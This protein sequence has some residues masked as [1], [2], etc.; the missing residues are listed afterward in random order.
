[1]H[2]QS[3]TEIHKL[4]P[5]HGPNVGCNAKHLLQG[6]H[7]KIWIFHQIKFG[8]MLFYALLQ[9][10]HCNYPGQSLDF[11]GS[12]KREYL[13]SL[14]SGHHRP[15]FARSWLCAY[16]HMQSFPQKSHNIMTAM[17]VKVFRFSHALAHYLSAFIKI[18]HKSSF[19]GHK[20]SFCSSLVDLSFGEYLVSFSSR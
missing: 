1:M 11:K 10:C 19:D 16:N 2:Y 17:S 8:P 14:H 12:E 20:S 5:S 3:N 15:G 18:G 13:S 4:W 9:W 7:Q 6:K